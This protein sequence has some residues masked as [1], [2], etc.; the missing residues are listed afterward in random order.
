M[1]PAVLERHDTVEVSERSHYDGTI[2]TP[3]D[4]C[5]KP[6]MRGYM[7]QLEHSL[8]ERDFAG[9]FLVSRS[10]GG[11]MTAASAREHPV[12]PILSG[13]AGG[14][15]GAAG[16]AR[17][18]DHPDLITIDMGGTSLDAS[19]VLDSRPV[20]HHEAEAEELLEDEGFDSDHRLFEC[21]VDARYAAQEHSATV[22]DPDSA[23]APFPAVEEEFARA[24]ERQYGHVMDEP[25][26]VT[27][28]R[29]RATGL[30]DKPELPELDRT[31]G[32]APTAR[33]RR[34]VSGVGGARD[35]ALH[36]RADLWAADVIPGP[37]VITERTATTV[38]HSGDHRAH[39]E[40]VIGLEHVEGEA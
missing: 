16:F 21:T 31:S 22:P 6:I 7:Q 8:A 15:V 5:I 12:N 2:A 23:D 26:E 3:L 1:R 14:V 18:I 39:G 11:A 4:A 32:P 30:V 33:G 20:A 36:A 37:A 17:M 29:V 24:H 28:F 10:G 27:T 19:L 25:I 40:L 38:L 9:R 13:P 34:A 35:Y